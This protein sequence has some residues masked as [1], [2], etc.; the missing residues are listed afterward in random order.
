MNRPDARVLVNGTGL[1]NGYGFNA[2][3]RTS[4]ADAGKNSAIQ[5][6]V[7]RLA[8]AS[9]WAAG[10]PSAWAS[11]WAQQTGSRSAVARAAVVNTTRRPA[12]R[13]ASLIASEQG[14]GL[15]SF[16]TAKVLPAEFTFAD[17]VD[18]RLRQRDQ[19]LSEER[20][21]FMTVT[22]HWFLPTSGDGRTVVEVF[23][24]NWSAGP[25]AGAR[26]TSTIWR[27]SPVAAE[28]LGFHWAC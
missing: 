7:L 19:C 25:A 4:L 15:F 18:H 5:D 14:P 24:R 10:H 28:Q 2:A 27:R 26:P 16:V 17:F 13:N 12:P 3:S 20:G 23:H 6:D 1:S 9:V 21:Q 8:K 22:L 11:V